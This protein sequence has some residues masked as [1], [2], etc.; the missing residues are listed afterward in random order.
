[1]SLIVYHLHKD[2]LQADS[3]GHQQMPI[4]AILLQHSPELI[5]RNP[6]IC[7]F[8]INKAFEDILCTLPGFFEELPQGENLVRGAAT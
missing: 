4:N 3:D 2:K 7:L 8:E 5:S 1:M 6:V